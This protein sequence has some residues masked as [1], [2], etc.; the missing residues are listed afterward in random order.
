MPGTIENQPRE[1]DPRFQRS[2][3][4]LQSALLELIDAKPLREISINALVKAAGL[5]RPTFYQH[6]T[7][8]PDAARRVALVR[9]AAAFPM[10]EPFPEGFEIS[11]GNIIDDVTETALPVIE[12]L[13]ENRRFYLRVLEEAGN[14]PF[15]DE[16]V[17]FLSGRYLPDAFELAARRLGARTDDLLTATAS[18][19][20]WLILRWLREGRPEETA[21]EMARRVASVVATMVPVHAD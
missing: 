9:L 14:A 8:V 17:T 5:T 18:G 11:A 1:T 6:F 7:D 4:A 19:T 15:F 20:M 10:P 2:L 16:V 12:H 13:Q 21:A 3:K